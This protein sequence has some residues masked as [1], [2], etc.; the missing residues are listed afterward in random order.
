MKVKQSS[1]KSGLFLVELIIAIV[2]F[3]A[4]SAV[5]VQLFVKAHLLSTRSQDLGTASLIAQN[6]AEVA[7]SLDA[8]GLDGMFEQLGESPAIR[9]YYDKTGVMIDE[10]NDSAPAYLLHVVYDAAQAPLYGADISVYK[11]AGEAAGELPQGE[12]LFSLHVSNY[13]PG[14]RTQAAG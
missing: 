2:F 14:S 3:A 12:A 11:V 13:Q 6:W 4:A 7:R 9:Q 8:D 5:C 10:G 1:G